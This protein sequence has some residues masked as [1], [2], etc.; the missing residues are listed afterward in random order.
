MKK[1][2][3]YSQR[4]L[5]VRVV[6]YW[7]SILLYSLHDRVCLRK[8]TRQ[9]AAALMTRARALDSHAV[10]LTKWAPSGPFLPPMQHA[11]PRRFF[12]ENMAPR[13]RNT[14][15]S[16]GH[17]ANAR[18]EAGEDQMASGSARSAVL[19]RARRPGVLFWLTPSATEQLARATRVCEKPV[20]G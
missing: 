5:L 4:F 17:K 1:G 19:C 9:R 18:P 7:S 14:P 6:N 13:L 20:V 12:T 2:F 16:L 15:R 8:F 3:A 10:P 11:S